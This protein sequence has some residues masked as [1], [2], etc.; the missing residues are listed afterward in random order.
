MLPERRYAEWRSVAERHVPVAWLAS[1]GGIMVC[2]PFLFIPHMPGSVLP[3]LGVG[4]ARWISSKVISRRMQVLRDDADGGQFAAS[5]KLSREVAYA[6]DEGLVSFEDGW[7]IFTGRRCTF[8]IGAADVFGRKWKGSDY[9]FRFPANDGELKVRM[10]GFPDTQFRLGILRWEYDARTS[11]SPVYP[12]R[13]P[14][15]YLRRR[16]RRIPLAAALPFALILLALIFSGRPKLV[17]FFCW[18]TLAAAGVGAAYSFRTQRILDR[19]AL[20]APPKDALP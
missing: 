9:Y 3:V 2:V 18:T 8:S 16:V 12:P 4:V 13:L 5:L 1:A 7:L 15:E 14:Q 11:E 10:I 17:P 19:I 6:Y 20:G